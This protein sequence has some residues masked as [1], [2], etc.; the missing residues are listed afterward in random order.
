MHYVYCT[1]TTCTVHAPNVT[2]SLLLHY[3]HWRVAAALSKH[4]RV[5]LKA[6][7]A[8][9]SSTPEY[10]VGYSVGDTVVSFLKDAR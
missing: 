2:L 10:D 1:F 9:G 3:S 8:V 6:M 7:P 5:L 4:Y